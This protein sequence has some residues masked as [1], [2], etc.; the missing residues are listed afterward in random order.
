[1]IC[2]RMQEAMPS[3]H[4]RLPWYGL[5]Q[6]KRSM[7]DTAPPLWLIRSPQ[8]IQSKTRILKTLLNNAKRY[9]ICSLKKIS[10]YMHMAGG[11]I[12]FYELRYYKLTGVLPPTWK[13]ESSTASTMV[14]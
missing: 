5:L 14:A 4:P 9:N 13:Y 3:S 12:I 10:I 11:N 6:D 7:P 1:M 2:I 8:S